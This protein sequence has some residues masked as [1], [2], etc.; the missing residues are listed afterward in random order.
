MNRALGTLGGGDRRSG[1]H[2]A[3]F[4]HTA[5]VFQPLEG[6]RNPEGTAK[7]GSPQNQ[8]PNQQS[9]QNQQQEKQDQ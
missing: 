7:A 9:P 5:T 8:Q 1:H 3:R 6:R 2:G 4:A